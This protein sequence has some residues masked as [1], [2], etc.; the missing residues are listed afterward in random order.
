MENFTGSG[1]GTTHLYTDSTTQHHFPRQTLLLAITTYLLHILLQW[2]HYLCTWSTVWKL[3]FFLLA[4]G[5]LKNLPLMW[6]L[7][8]VNAFRF[9]MRSQRPKVKCGPNHIFQPLITESYCPLMEIDFNIHKSNS[10]YFSDV[11]VARTHLFCTLFT[12]GIEQMRGGTSAI[13][14]SKDPIFGIA[15]GAVNCH[16]KKELKP[17][18]HYEMWTRVVSWDE[19][20][21]WLVTHF[22]R[23][24]ATRPKSYS[25]YPQQTT[26]ALDTKSKDLDPRAGVVASALSKCVFKQGR[27]TVS[28]EFM[29]RASGLLPDS[30]L[31]DELDIQLGAEMKAS[32]AE[33][34]TSAKIEEERLRGQ[35]IANTLSVGSQFD[36]EEAFTGEAEA[37]GRH[38]DGAGIVG[39]VSTLAQ[40]AG[41]KK[42]QI[43]FDDG[44][45][46]STETTVPNSDLAKELDDSRPTFHPGNLSPETS[47]DKGKFSFPHSTGAIENQSFRDQKT[48]ENALNANING[49]ASSLHPPREN[50]ARSFRDMGIWPRDWQKNKQAIDN[51]TQLQL[52]ENQARGSNGQSVPGCNKF[53]I[54]ESVNIGGKAGQLKGNEPRRSCDSLRD[55]KEILRDINFNSRPNTQGSAQTTCDLSAFETISEFRKPSLE[56]QDSRTP[57]NRGAELRTSRENET[58]KT[59]N[60]TVLNELFADII[61]SA[62]PSIRHLASQKTA[63]EAAASINKPKRLS[64]PIEEQRHPGKVGLW[65]DKFMKNIDEIVDWD[66]AQPS[67]ISLASKSEADA[68][69]ARGNDD[70]V[71]ISE[72]PQE[73]EVVHP[74]AIAL[75]FLMVGLCLSVFLISLDRTI[76]TT[77]IPYISG[78]FQSY[79]DV[80]WYG[81]A[82]L[83]TACAFQ[84]LYGKIFT[85][86]SIKWSYLAANTLFEI[87]SLICGI[88]PNSVTLIIGRAIAGVG[89]AGILTGSFVV[90]AHSVPMHKRPVFTAAVGLMFGVGATVGPL[91][92][93][94]FTDLV[95]WRW[96]FYFNLPVG[97]ATILAMILFFNPKNN[98]NT[99]RSFGSRVLELDIIGNILLLGAC[100][101]LFIALQYTEV[102]DAWSNS[103]V[104]GLLVGFGVTVVVF[105]FWL[106][107][108]GD[109][110]LIPLDILRQRSVLA[111]CLFSFFI[112]SALILH[113]YYLPQ[114]FQAVKNTSAITS[115]VDMIPYVVCNAVFSLLA[116][117]I[118]SKSGYFTPPTVVGTAIATIGC[119]LISTL[120]VNTT[121]PQW[122]GYEILSAAGFGLAIQQGFTAVQTVLP[123]EKIPI[124]TAAVVA[125]QSLGGAIFVSVGNN[126]LQNQLKSYSTNGQLPGVDIQAVLDAGATGLRSVVDADQL[127]ALL[128]A[129]NEALQKVFLVAIPMTGLAFL[130]SLFLEWKSV[131]AQKP[132]AEGV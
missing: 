87:G 84:P 6:T 129:Y 103:K 93:G 58:T 32:G 90:V 80:G 49:E 61:S 4:I 24:D 97:G 96:C 35:K 101:M 31:N 88:A 112:Y 70:N 114:W 50:I 47:D 55:I 5:N 109:K 38:I 29:L 23:K 20:W 78:E 43:L 33:E 21:I 130:S 95:T 10:S 76:V 60:D 51:T 14:G 127:P 121:S 18:E 63:G 37:L 30:L 83:L 79:A 71:V 34:W 120:N 41:L 98:M 68:F 56:D 39:V 40:L 52:L 106:W 42:K 75:T 81:S 67:T 2:L 12:Q 117:I 123:L 111:S 91:L 105:G 113:S 9:C 73:L 82:Y 45:R 92:G 11:D 48:S 57:L 100:V 110:A 7:R 74:G 25:L 54:A 125:S 102:G 86:F 8:I 116:G 44:T 131:K 28:P 46:R 27:K 115:G 132:V 119:G 59:R 1:A 17:Y 107:W 99:R 26:E 66:A 85:L 94:V 118:V 53:P 69:A 19:K 77:A 22:V 128:G 72:E 3:S 65:S 124:G 13:N 64:T 104:I 36:L 62:E 126:I 122:I 15:L 16:F 89:S 108:R